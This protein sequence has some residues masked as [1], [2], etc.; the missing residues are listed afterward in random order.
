[1]FLGI[2]N[3]SGTRWRRIE[4]AACS[5]S[6]SGRGAPGWRG[7]RN[8]CALLRRWRQG[9]PTPFPR[10]TFNGC[11]TLFAGIEKLTVDFT[12]FTDP[13]F[14]KAPILLQIPVRV[15]YAHQELL[16]RDRGPVPQLLLPLLGRGEESLVSKG[17]DVAF[18]GDFRHPGHLALQLGLEAGAEAVQIEEE[19]R[20][21]FVQ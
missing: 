7:R 4:C 21:D 16:Q 18:V 19:T 13:T 10:C 11:W 17:E 2:G 14:F 12:D 6:R 20:T 5:T 15:L 1:M 9:P 8:R 3:L